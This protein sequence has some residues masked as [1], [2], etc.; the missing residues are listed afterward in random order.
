MLPSWESDLRK[1]TGMTKRHP[2]S[3]R[4]SPIVAKS[5]KRSGRHTVR[6]GFNFEIFIVLM[7][8]NWPRRRSTASDFHQ[9]TV[10]QVFFDDLVKLIAFGN[11]FAFE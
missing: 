1:H 2:K 8:G 5:M 3:P 4:G 7:R 11:H 10:H 6:S 9:P